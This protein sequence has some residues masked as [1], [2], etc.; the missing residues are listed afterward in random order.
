MFSKFREIWAGRE[1]LS[2]EAWANR[3]CKINLRTI[4]AHKLE[5]TPDTP[6]RKLALLVDISVQTVMDHLP[7]NLGMKCDGL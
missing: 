5:L 3:L 4:S 7:H 2:D 6:V 1:N